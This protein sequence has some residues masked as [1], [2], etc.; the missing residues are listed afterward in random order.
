MTCGIA[1]YRMTFGSTSQ[2]TSPSRAHCPR[3]VMRTEL[4]GLTVI[5]CLAPPPLDHA[6]GPRSATDH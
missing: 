2:R 6:T 4:R 3:D 5:V 1:R